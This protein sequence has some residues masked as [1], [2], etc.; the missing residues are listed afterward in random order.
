MINHHSNSQRSQL[1]VLLGMISQSQPKRLCHWDSLPLWMPHCTT[2]KVESQQNNGGI[3]R[4]WTGHCTD[5]DLPLKWCGKWGGH[6][7]WVGTNG[8]TGCWSCLIFP[9][10]WW[11]V[12]GSLYF[13]ML[14]KSL[15]LVDLERQPS[16]TQSWG[17]RSPIWPGLVGKISQEPLYY[18][19][20]GIQVAARSL[21]YKIN[22]ICYIHSRSF[23]QEMKPQLAISH[24]HHSKCSS[25]VELQNSFV[26]RVGK[27]CSSDSL[28]TSSHNPKSC[29]DMLSHWPTI[30]IVNPLIT[31]V[32]YFKNST[33]MTW[34]HPSIPR[35]WA[36]L[37][38]VRDIQHDIKSS[39]CEGMWIFGNQW[40]MNQN[41]V[42][43]RCCK[44]IYRLKWG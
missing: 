42:P 15:V 31:A 41:A 1:W 19:K 8:A 37:R 23:K 32:T 39:I 43:S 22:D 2:G 24:H 13:K 36:E 26:Q 7:Q 34:H 6:H 33:K 17:Q 3:S 25:I 4:A 12:I 40:G 11:S 30:V 29:Y 18:T 16:C 21:I 20:P 14:R 44:K 10:K 38:W 28:H 27:P 9:K 35:R 5:S